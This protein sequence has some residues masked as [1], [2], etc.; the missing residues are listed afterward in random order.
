VARVLKPGGSFSAVISHPEAD[1]LER[2]DAAGNVTITLFD[3]KVSITYPQH[4]L[5]EYF[6]GTFNEYFVLEK[7][8]EYC[9]KEQD[10]GKRN[11]LNNTLCF[12]ARRK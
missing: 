1:A 11:D 8:M 6:T 10:R 7:Q 3:G 2:R 4:V 9:G 12:L 5:D